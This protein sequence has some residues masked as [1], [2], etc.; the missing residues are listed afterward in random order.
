MESVLSLPVRV[1]DESPVVARPPAARSGVIRI[2]LFLLLSVVMLFVTDYLVDSGLR[3]ITTS[4]F[5]VYNRLVNGQ[6]N[7]DIIISGS[8]RALNNV[9]PR[10]IQGRT[11]RTTF[12]IGIN[13][14]QTDMQVAVLKTYLKHNVRPSLVIH[15]LDSF[16]FVTSHGGVFFPGQYL[17]Y[18]HEDAIYEALSAIN[19]NTWK[20]RYLPLYGYAVEDMNFTWLTGLGGRLGWNPREDHYFGFQPRFARWTAE[21]ARL[22]DSKPEGIRFEIEPAGVRDFEELLRRCKDLGIPVLLVYSPVYFEEQALEVNRDE[23]FAR[24]KE[25]AQ[26][27]DATL[28]DYSRSPISFRRD[29]FV[30]S[31]HLNADGAAAFSAAL[32][33]DLASSGLLGP[34]R[35]AD[36]RGPHES[37]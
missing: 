29:Y 1:R 21:L 3:R 37:R 24:F 30:N 15:S 26:R 6:I 13:G 10:V 35:Q 34:R 18:L 36:G 5:G 22:K 23:I 14:S 17:P 12:N 20:A 31:Q 25:L 7:T 32:A 19:A 33:G 2:L 27:Y 8:S 28:W 11:G 4:S 9:D 16:T